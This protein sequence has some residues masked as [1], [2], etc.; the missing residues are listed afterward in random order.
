M[1]HKLAGALQQMYRIR[2]RCA[3]KELHVYVRMEYVDAA[4]GRISQTCNRPAVMQEL[5]NF[6][7]RIFASPQTTDARWLPIHLSSKPSFTNFSSQFFRA[8]EVGSR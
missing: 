6:V 4:E 1:A 2:Q 7:P 8:M 3:V 5:P